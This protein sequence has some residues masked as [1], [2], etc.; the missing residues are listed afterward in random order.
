MH[1][2]RNSTTSIKLWRACG[3]LFHCDEKEKR[4]RPFLHLQSMF[5][6]L[7]WDLLD[8]WVYY[9]CTSPRYFRVFRKP[10]HSF[11]IWISVGR[12]FCSKYRGKAGFNRSIF[13]P[14]IRESKIWNGLLVVIPLVCGKAKAQSHGVHPTLHSMGVCLIVFTNYA[15]ESL[16]IHTSAVLLKVS[17]LSIKNIVHVHITTHIYWAFTICL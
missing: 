13:P 7:H 10:S 6:F 8:Q 17:E 14:L 9:D 11:L 2:H 4:K 12:N 16:T 15:T 3:Q 1:T 5:T